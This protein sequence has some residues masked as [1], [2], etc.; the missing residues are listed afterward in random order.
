MRFFLPRAV[1]EAG[2][3]EPTEKGVRLVQVPP[4]RIAAL[5]F[6]GACHRRRGAFTSGR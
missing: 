5:R 6:T 4:E 1:A 3:P 2:A